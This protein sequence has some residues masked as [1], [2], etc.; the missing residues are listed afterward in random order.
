[1]T[2]RP[3]LQRAVGLI[4]KRMVSGL[5]RVIFGFAREELRDEDG[6]AVVALAARQ[7]EVGDQARRV[8]VAGCNQVVQGGRLLVM[9]DHHRSCRRTLRRCKRRRPDEQACHQSR[10]GDKQIVR[11]RMYPSCRCF[12]RE[13][14]HGH[15]SKRPMAPWWSA[16]GEYDA[17]TRHLLVAD[18]K[19]SALAADEQEAER[20]EGG[21]GKVRRERPAVAAAARPRRSAPARGAR[22]SPA[23]RLRARSRSRPP[24]RSARRGAR[25]PPGRSGRPGSPARVR[26]PRRPARREPRTGQRPSPPAARAAGSWPPPSRPADASRR[27]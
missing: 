5:F 27:R 1:M 19:N 20:E 21:D 13:L 12:L 23:R 24:P 6:A 16:G 9:A 8:G 3:S 11:L 25:A 26:R 18:D 14:R 10:P 22:G 2:W 4:V 7:D 17:R 15:G